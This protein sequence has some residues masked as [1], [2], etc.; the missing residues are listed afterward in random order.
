MGARLDDDKIR[1]RRQDHL[2]SF[3]YWFVPAHTLS[4]TTS[5]VSE[6]EKEVYLKNADFSGMFRYSSY[7]SRSLEEYH[8]RNRRK[9]RKW[10][11]KI[12]DD[13]TNNIIA[14]TTLNIYDHANNTI[15]S[16]NNKKT[17]VDKQQ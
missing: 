7:W 16:N 15:Y 17:E 4:A 10:G 13:A 1:L 12:Y 11:L 14:T 8:V 9:N 3:I 6:A 2:M 5:V